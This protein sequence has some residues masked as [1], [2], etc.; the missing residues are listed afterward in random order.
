MLLHRPLQ[1]QVARSAGTFVVFGLFSLGAHAEQAPAMPQSVDD[2]PFGSE[3]EAVIWRQDELK[4][5]ERLLRQLCFDL[6]NNQ[7]ARGAA[8]RLAELQEKA[9]Q[10][11]LLPAFIAG[12]H[13]RGSD[14]K[15]EIWEEW[16]DFSAGFVD[17]EEKVGVLIDAAEQED[18]RAATRAF[19]EVGLSC[20]S[21]HRA[22][23]YD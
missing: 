16:D 17:L 13:G 2:T 6:V 22:Y 21:C 20:R 3:R 10:A 7:D 15:P 23:R 5:L 8:P 12:T 19:S 18:Y 9:T 11:H 14:A 1:S 4:D